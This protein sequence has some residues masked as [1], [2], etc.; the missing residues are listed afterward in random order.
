LEYPE[1]ALRGTWINAVTPHRSYYGRATPNLKITPEGLNLLEHRRACLP[2]FGIDDLKNGNSSKPRNE[3]L[4]DVFFQ[5]GNIEPGAGAP[6]RLLMNV[7][8]PGCRSTEF[9]EDFG[10]PFPIFSARVSRGKGVGDKVG[11]KS[12]E[13]VG[14]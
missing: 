10:G 14:D 2:A 11:D 12:G 13:R 8:R 6:S 9:R 7:K 5:G 3:F 1:D 4:A